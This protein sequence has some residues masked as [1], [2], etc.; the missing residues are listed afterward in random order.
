MISFPVL[1][2]TFIVIFVAELPD[3]T[4]LAALILSTKYRSRDVIVGCWLAFLVQTIVAVVAGSFLALLPAE[5]MRIA[6][7]LGFLVFAVFSLKRNGKADEKKEVASGER[8]KSLR[9]A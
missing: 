1:F 6:S 8:G 5:P 3:K 2:S 4:A 7:G 9:P